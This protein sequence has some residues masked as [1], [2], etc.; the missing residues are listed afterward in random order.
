MKR[1]GKSKTPLYHQLPII[2][3]NLRKKLGVSCKIEVGVWHHTSERRSKHYNISFVPGFGGREC[4]I[5]YCNSWSGLLSE[6]NKL[7]KG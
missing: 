3:G 5:I 6:Y 1:I 2:V 7:M 4:S